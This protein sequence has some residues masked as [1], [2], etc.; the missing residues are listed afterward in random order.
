[1]REPIR[2][3]V[4]FQAN[5]RV[6]QVGGGDAFLTVSEFVRE[7]LRWTGTKTACEEGDCGSCTVLVGQPTAQGLTY[8]PMNSCIRFVHQLDGC[9]LVT[10]EGL[11][12][13]GQLTAVQRALVDCHGS[14]CGFCTP[15]FAMTMTATLRQAGSDPG[16]TPPV[17]WPVELAG[18]LCRCTGY[19]P[20]LEAAR[21]REKRV[22]SDE[23]WSQ[24]TP[25]FAQRCEELRTSAFDIR[26]THRG[27]SRRV[28]SPVTLDDALRWRGELLEAEV[29]AGAT[30]LGVGW[31]KRRQSAA[32]WLDLGRVAE[33]RPI[34]LS[35]AVSGEGAEQG[36]GVLDVG[37][38]ATWADLL[39]QSETACPEFAVL[40]RRFGGPQIREVGTI[41]GNLV[42][43]SAIADSLPCLSVL[44]ATID[45]ASSR[46]FRSVGISQFITA[47][48]RTVLQGDELLVRVR[49]PLPGVSERFR[50]YKI[51]R[52]RDLDIATITAAI[53]IGEESGQITRAAIAVGGAG[54]MVRRLD[55][56][57]TWLRGR[58]WNEATFT[59]AGNLAAL[60]VS[61]WSDLRGSAD[62][63]RQVVRGI[64]HR[65]FHE[66]TTVSVDG[67][68][69]SIRET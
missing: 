8:R 59:E 63:R 14:Q 23:A 43:A 31:T 56:V 62:Y 38:M 44:N 27:V 26:G 52:R 47:N 5:Q 17:D 24:L 35:P 54:P 10:I 25:Q 46:G 40:L 36:V 30:D 61:P 4:E 18:H 21:H 2:D 41:G 49:I 28:V 48:H 3:V 66:S 19:L 16:T 12:A 45:L 1:M 9:H 7:R 13:D 57:E 33:L 58:P 22:R 34:R 39:R 55:R 15:G 64:V 20:I 32:T 68:E 29:I 6:C 50:L 67:N 37:A 53:R 51:S 69:P 42:N 11:A 60:D 65:F